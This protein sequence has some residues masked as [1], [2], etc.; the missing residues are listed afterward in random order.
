MKP[1][2]KIL[3]KLLHPGTPIVLLGVAVAIASM[4]YVFGFGHE[5][6]PVAYFLYA[7][8][9]YATVIFCIQVISSSKNGFRTLL[10]KNKYVHRYLTDIPFKIHVSLYC[11]LAVNLLYAGVKLFSGIYYRSVWFITL[12][13][14]YSFLAVMRFLL[15]YHV[16]KNALGTEYAAELKQYRLCGILLMMMNTALTGVVVLVIRKNEGFAYVGYFIYVMAMYA[17]YSVI[18]ATVNIIKYKK[19]NS[20]VLSAAK[21][22]NLAAALVSMLALETA[23][24]TQFGGGDT[25]AFRQIM[26][27]TTGGAVCTI[28]LG[29]AIHMIQ[30]ATKKI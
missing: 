19:Y 3:H 15:L 11:A 10:H 7:L 24:L 27:G 25:P 17:F 22:I 28:I 1:F 30:F 14:Y 29:I 21:N 2:K 18:T 16:Q 6:E 8:S 4:V 9:A 26:I 12:A 23:M 13:V 5:Q 20:P